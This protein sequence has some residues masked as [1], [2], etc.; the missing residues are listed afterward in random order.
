MDHTPPSYPAIRL[1]TRHGDALA[2][3]AGLAPVAL[4]LWAVLGAGAGW[5]WLVAGLAGG[6]GLGLVMRS[7]VEVLRILADTL[8]PR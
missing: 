5:G 8:M 3:V 6:G 2:L 1:F 4:A 7:Y